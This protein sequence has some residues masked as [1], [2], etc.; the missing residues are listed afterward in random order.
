MNRVNPQAVALGGALAAAEPLVV[1]VRG[2]LYERCL[3][4]ATS[5]LETPRRSR[6]ATQD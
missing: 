1:A 6:A 2:V 5:D 3:P 4:L